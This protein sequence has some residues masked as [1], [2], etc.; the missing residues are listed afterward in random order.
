MVTKR[1]LNNRKKKAEHAADL[2]F[3]QIA[4]ANRILMKSL[5]FYYAKKLGLTNCYRCSKPLTIDDFTID[6]KKSWRNE[7]NAKELFF[8]PEN[9]G[10]SHHNCNSSAFNHGYSGYARGCRCDKCTEGHRLRLRKIRKLK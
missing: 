6:H 7:E 1:T 3:N 10:F 4:H 8:D 5:V 2:G 9:I